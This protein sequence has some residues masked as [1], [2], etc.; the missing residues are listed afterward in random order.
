MPDGTTRNPVLRVQDLTVRFRRRGV[1]VAAVNGVDFSLAAGETLTILGESGSGKSVSLKALMGLLPGYASVSGQIWLNGREILGLPPAELAKLRGAAVSMIFQEPMAALDPVYTIG[2]QIAETIVQHE[3]CDRRTA[4]RRALGLLE[5]VR[6]PSAERRLRNYPHEMSGGMRQRAMIA[7][8]LACKPS[9]LLADEP[10]TALD[11]SVQIQ[12]LLLLRQLQQELG[13]AIVFV[14][15]DIGAAAEISDRI[16]VMYAGRFVETG[17]TRQVMRSPMHP[18][19]QGLLAS[20]VH[21]GMRGRTLETIPGSPPNLAHLLPGC[22]FAP[23][24]RHA[25][26]ACRH[27]D[28]PVVTR[29]DGAMVRCVRVAELIKA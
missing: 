22:P 2:A 27:G 7:L 13:M 16:A 19:T 6:I 26:D 9:V 15:H 4:M 11:V 1:D 17:T 28:I 18:Y 25:M 21:G 14:T 3:G 20:T 24:C 23:R 10:T 5:Q 8:A 29:Q 12:I